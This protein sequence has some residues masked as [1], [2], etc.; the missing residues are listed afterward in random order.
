MKT[1]LS[2]IL[3]LMFLSLANFALAQTSPAADTAATPVPKPEKFV[4]KHSIKIDNKPINYT[5]TVGTIILKNEKDEAIASFG[6]TAYTKDGETDMSKRPITFSYN[7]GPG[8]SS[9]W[10]HMGVMGPRR[11]IVNDPEPNGPAP[12]KLEDNNY[13]ILDVSDIVMMDPVGTGLSRAVGKG[14]NTDFWGVDGDIKSVSQFIKNYVNENERWNSPKYLLGESYGTFRS[15][16]VADYLQSNMGISVNGIV[17][18]SNVLDIRT[19][20]FNPGDDLP[21]VVNLPTY[22]ATS[23]YHNKVNNKPANLYDFLKDARLFA[24]GEYAQA[25][26]KGDQLGDDEREKVLN[27]LVAFTGISKD[28]WDKANLRVNQPQFSQELLRNS[29]VA[30]GRLDSRY[31]GIAQDLLSEYASTDPQSED[32]SPAFISAFMNYYTTEL[33]V[34]KDKTYNT[35]AYSLTDFKWDWKH[36]RSQGLFGDAASPNTGPDLLN[37]MS[38]NSKMKVLVLNGI[39][40]LATPFGGSEYTFDHLGLSKKIK[41]NIILKYYEAGHMM[42]IHNESAAKFKKDVAE[43]ITG[44]L[45]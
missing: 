42:Y 41:S 4:T 34:S 5:A 37:A 2:A 6:Y 31:K 26:M 11:V 45:K 23:W 17:L 12:Y 15:A 14:K 20:S 35:S 22:A 8:S 39:Y 1:S 33:K 40:D 3:I 19:L 44:L 36:A 38:N 30:V 9:M 29:G 28:Y 43:F 10:L 16:G 7:G 32:I 24:F 27:K 18:V 13:S 21:F 25:L